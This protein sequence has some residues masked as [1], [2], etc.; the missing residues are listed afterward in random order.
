[1][2]WSELARTLDSR[3]LTGQ[4]IFDHIAR[5]VEQHAWIG[6][7]GRVYRRRSWGVAARVDGLYVDPGTRLL[8]HAP[9]SRRYHGGLFFEAQSRLRAFG[10]SAVTAG[11][12]RRYRID[13]LRLWDRRDC[14]WFVH[15]YRRVP[16]RLI[17]V[18]TRSDGTEVPIYSAACLE[19]V[20]TK[21]ANRNEVWA[22]RSIL[23]LDPLVGKRK[24]ERVTGPRCP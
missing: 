19:R 23:E 21:Q 12:I 15:T 11:D 22:A 2:V 13:G 16:E 10:V 4:H 14:G 3:S 9:R 17:R 5:E 7:D 8:C 18:L 24:N 20:A 6:D 1:M